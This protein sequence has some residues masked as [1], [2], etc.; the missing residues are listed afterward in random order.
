[1]A[2]S[3]G[4]DSTVLLAAMT[5][6]GAQGFARGLRALHVDHG[7]HAESSRW[8]EDARARAVALGVPFTILTVDAA[9]PRGASPEAAAREARYTALAAALSDEEVLLTGQH[10][11]DQ[12]ETL[13]LRLL[14]GSGPAGLA[15]MPVLRRLGR[16]WLA[17]PLLGEPR[18]GLRSWAVAEGLGWLD[19]P[20]NEDLAF[21]RV[22][23]RR[24]VMPVIRRR[25]P[26]VSRALARAAGHAREASGLLDTLARL[27]RQGASGTDW[28]TLGALVNLPADRARNALRGWL[29]DQSLPVPP[30]TRLREIL[31]LIRGR[32]D[33]QGEVR[34]GSVAVRRWRQ[35]L[36]A[37]SGLPEEPLA[38]FEW[39]DPRIPCRLPAGLGV[40]TLDP[41][42]RESVSVAPLEIRWRQGGERIRLHPGGPRRAL[43]DL[44]RESGIRPWMRGRIPLVYA[45]GRLAAVGDLWTA[46]ERAGDLDVRWQDRPRLR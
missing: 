31:G 8:A 40:L 25:W 18:A 23:L 35:R 7:L 26:T 34:W 22:Y 12:A 27:D 36:Y 38:P 24:E 10:L 11:D 5:R 32:A 2:F 4:L 45:D 39:T 17:R 15:G 20:A 19:D 3:G 43:K 29:R 16:G 14:R 33:G 30:E 41:P 46:V 37:I 28:I 42:P 9:P 13:F 44:L 1:M 21:D 6:L